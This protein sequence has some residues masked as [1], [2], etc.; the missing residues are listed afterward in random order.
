M[1]ESK[2]ISI[3]TLA[4]RF[5]ADLLM[6]ALHREGVPAILRTFEETPYD[7]LFVPQRGWG[8]IQVPEEYISEAHE[9][10][11]PLIQDLQSEGVNQDSCESGPFAWD[12]LAEADT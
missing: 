5:E 8:Q 9:V 3:Y 1:N 10:M 2:L 6:D 7:G 11:T 12:E 4:N